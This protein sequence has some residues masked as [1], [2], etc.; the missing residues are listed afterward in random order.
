MG[1][2]HLA[3]AAVLASTHEVHEMGMKL[4]HNLTHHHDCM[5]LVSLFGLSDDEMPYVTLEE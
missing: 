4:L 1:W 3:A 2:N 5:L